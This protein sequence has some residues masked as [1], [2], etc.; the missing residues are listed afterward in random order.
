MSTFDQ[1]SKIP[2]LTAVNNASSQR[3]LESITLIWYD[4]NIDETNGTKQTMNE[5]REINNSVVFHTDLDACIGYIKNVTAEK[6]FLV[7]SGKFA[8]R[9]LEKNHELSQV[10]S[11]FIFC[12]KPDRYEK[13]IQKYS[14]LIGIYVQRQDL[15][16]S[17]RENI[18]LV[19][20]HLETFSFYS[21]HKQK[22]TRDLSK[23]SAEFL[24]FQMF[25]DVILR[26]P[27]DSH[28][29]QQM[30]EFCRYYYYGNEK[31]LKFICEF[32]R[33]YKSNMAIR[34]YTKETFLYKTVNKVLRTEDLEQLHTFR[35]FIAD[36]SLNLSTEYE[37]LIRKGE[38]IIMLYR[39][40][41]M[42][43]EELETLKQNEHSLISTN[44]FLS[45][46]RSKE[47]ALAFAQK[48]TKRTDT[49]AVLYEIECNIEQTDSI[50]FA[51]IA[52]FSDYPNEAEVLFDLGSTFEIISAKK[53]AELNLYLVKLKASDKGSKVAKEYIELN[54][55]DEDET[56]LE[57]IFGKLLI[58]MGQYDQS[59]KYFQ[60]LL[61]N[62]QTQKDDIAK[63]NNLIGSTYYNK[64]DLDKALEYYQLAYD[65]MMNDKPIRIKDSARPLTNIGL[66]YHRKGQYSRALELYLKSIEI[67]ETYYGKEHITATKT[68]TNIG[69]IYTE[70][71]QYH[72]ALQYYKNIRRIQQLYL[73]S[74]HLATAMTLNNIAVVYTK[75]NA[76][77]R[78]LEYYQQSLD[79][80]KRILPPDH[81]DIRVTM[82]N[83]ADIN[84]EINRLHYPVSYSKMCQ[85]ST[86]KSTILT[87]NKPPFIHTIPANA[88]WVQNGITVAGSK[89]SGDATNQLNWPYDLFV[90]DDQTVFIADNGNHRI[91]QWKNGDT[92]NGQ[93]VAGGKGQG[94]G[95]HQLSYPT[96][97]L[98]DKETDSLIIC[99]R[100]N[101]RTVRWSL[102]SGATQGE[103]LTGHIDCRGLAMDEQR[104]LY[105]SDTEKHEVRRY[106]LGE[107][108]GTLVA[109]GNGK[110]GGRNQLN[111]PTYLFVDRQ[112]N[113]YV[114]DSS[115][116][117]VMKWNKGAKEG[118]V[119]AGGHGQGN[120]LTQLSHPNG[121]FV[122]TLGTLYV[123][124]SHNHRVMR[125]TQG[126][127]KQGTVIVGG[128]G[129]GEGGNQFN[130]PTGL[131]FDRHGNLYVVDMGNHRV[132]R[133]SIE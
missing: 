2:P 40:L 93:V 70:S 104:Y 131:S 46:S 67:F 60:S 102:R 10:D 19:E 51:D 129:E 66:I 28:A 8:E 113:V 82:A 125:W 114:S 22:S 123:A 13:L 34:W 56:S 65:L 49:I 94:N 121:I 35:F 44:G 120:A 11:I 30:I 128:N 119:I 98:I 31:E 100:D 86:A 127:K 55:K 110:G 96:D 3:N 54:R 109:G 38:K 4:P 43:K 122:D 81:N 111:E 84:T 39:G 77:D 130:G 62:D 61:V 85:A 115:N 95:L 5:L 106:Q 89:V 23:E 33:D 64:G 21:Q 80:K 72:R 132:Q 133:F 58:D 6:I 79:M 17:L 75:M 16:N 47:Q 18:I 42:E 73:P 50:I 91:M 117:R 59:L 48:P 101:R 83:I 1:S 45:T 24:W 107:K 68:L 20:K 9:I 36:L 53:N 126:D 74:D 71:R 105:L 25:K 97:V 32:A 27:R 69:N 63:I 57:L 92:T 14:K 88:I 29:K 108:N 99:D 103:I 78:A 7:T 116:H 12:S 41:K 26:L 76:I 87:Q 90:D 112:R 124:D 118:I 52:K 15:L 37:K